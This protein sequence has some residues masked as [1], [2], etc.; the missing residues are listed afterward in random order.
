MGCLD[1]EDRSK[2]YDELQKASLIEEMSADE[3]SNPL[4]ESETQ[5]MS[6]EINRESLPHANCSI[7]KK[8]RIAAL[9]GAT[10]YG[11]ALQ[12][13]DSTAIRS[14]FLNR[15]GF[16]PQPGTDERQNIRPSTGADRPKPEAIQVNLKGDHG[17]E[18]RTLQQVGSLSSV[19]TASTISSFSKSG[20]TVSFGTVVTVHPIPNHTAYSERVRNSYWTS[21]NEMRENAARNCFEF[22]AE[23]WDWRKAAEEDEMV[24]YQ[25]ERVH[26]IH[27]VQQYN[28]RQHFSP[29]A[30]IHSS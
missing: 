7:A 11:P 10:T 1:S 2:L 4:N 6:T 24:L 8:V 25:G 5:A 22:A 20:K 17:T 26:P 18:D 13:A 15:L 14:R 9:D 12:R 29:S 30:S 27:F 3:S 23:D 19:S 28:L 16:Q 21:S